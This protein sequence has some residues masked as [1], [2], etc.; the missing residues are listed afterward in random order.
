MG[1]PR[2]S[3]LLGPGIVMSSEAAFPSRRRPGAS[4]PANGGWSFAFEIRHAGTPAPHHS[5]TLGAVL[6]FAAVLL[7][8]AC[9]PSGPSLE[10]FD[11]SRSSWVEAEPVVVE[12]FSVD[13]AGD[14]VRAT[15][16]FLRAD[17]RITL[18]IELYLEP[19]ARFVDGSHVSRIGGSQFTGPL[20][21]ESVEFFGG[22]NEGS[23]VGGAFV[24]ENPIDGAKYRLRFPP[25][26]S[27]P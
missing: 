10:R 16:T 1:N 17:D 14:E 12:S 25:T 27:Q 26:P 3:A 13:R 5:P 21:S 4:R 24:L 23:S 19:P 7:L 22:Q 15:G 8:S 9:S 6:A 18:A 11:D 20:A 2:A